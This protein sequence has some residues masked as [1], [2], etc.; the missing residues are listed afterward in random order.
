MQVLP[1]T[2][3]IQRESR[4]CE[5]SIANGWATVAMVS[6]EV[7]VRVRKRDKFPTNVWRDLN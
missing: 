5:S 3:E 2:S 7:E 4:N 6:C 1:N